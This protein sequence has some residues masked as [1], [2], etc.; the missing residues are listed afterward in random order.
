MRNDG[1]VAVILLLVRVTEWQRKV[2]GLETCVGF[3]GEIL[4]PSAVE[5]GTH[6]QYYLIQTDHHSHG[7][8]HT[9]LLARCRLGETKVEEKVL[10]PERNL[11]VV[12]A[13]RKK[14]RGAKADLHQARL[15]IPAGWSQCSPHGCSP[16]FRPRLYV[17]VSKHQLP[18]LC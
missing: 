6:Y 14:Q 12:E 4:G 5:R 17:E 1:N 15:N 3:V 9:R 11:S 7:N 10:C 18:L 2:Q 16:A 8:I 13:E